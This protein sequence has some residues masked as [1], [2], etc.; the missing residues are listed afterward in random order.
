MAVVVV[1]P[2]RDSTPQQLIAQ[3]DWLA[4]S[5]CFGLPAGRSASWCGAHPTRLRQILLNALKFT[6]EAR[7]Y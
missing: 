5:D 6:E 2:H 4:H 1:V 7:W 3:S